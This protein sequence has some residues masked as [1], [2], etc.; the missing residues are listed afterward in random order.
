[1]KQRPPTPA[2]GGLKKKSAAPDPGLFVTKNGWTPAPDH[3]TPAPKIL[4][5]LLQSHFIIQDQVERSQQ[6]EMCRS[7]IVLMW[8]ALRRSAKW[9]KIWPKMLKF[10]KFQPFLKKAR[11]KVHLIWG[12]LGVRV[13]TIN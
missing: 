1:M 2:S 12:P 7:M 4:L 13:R 9:G 10:S 3:R 5:Y 6:S 11:K 8:S